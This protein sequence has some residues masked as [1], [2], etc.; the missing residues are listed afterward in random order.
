MRC[1]STLA[2]ICLSV[3]IATAVDVGAPLQAR[4]DCV[5]SI[6]N[7]IDFTGLT[8]T[9]SGDHCVSTDYL[10]TT[11]TDFSGLVSL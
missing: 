2:A 7:G 10:S 9:I 6:V 1:L 11:R 3:A 8:K 4:E 5:L